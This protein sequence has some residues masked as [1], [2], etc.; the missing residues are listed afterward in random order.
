MMDFF[1]E[2]AG[3]ITD[4]RKGKITIQDLLQMRAGYP[5][6]ETSP[7]LFDTLYNG[8][9][10]SHLVDFALRSDPGTDFAY[11]N[12]TSHLLA[13]IVARACGTDFK[14][15]AQVNLFSPLGAEVGDPWWQDWEGYYTG[16]AGVRFTLR[17]AAKFGML[18]LN[19]GKYAGEQIVSA[20]WVSNSLE[21]YSENVSSGAPQSGRMGR[22]FQNV[23]YGYQWW[24][25][26][27]GDHHLNYAAGHGGQLIVLM[28][29]HDM[30][31]VVASDPFLGQH[32]SQAWKHEQ[33]NFNLVGKF[34][35]SLPTER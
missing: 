31:V 6:E 23:G 14:S 13:V 10:P 5:W 16:H 26:N 18:Y 3:N 11:S 35:R 34:I 15:Y 2:F 8:F 19:D 12:L 28:E 29:D 27:V 22:Y 20:D 21:T 24:S 33:A 1:P 32:D 17:D 7:E 4:Q 30:V 9:R 25:A